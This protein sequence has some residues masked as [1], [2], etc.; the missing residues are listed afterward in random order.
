MRLRRDSPAY[1]LQSL[2]LGREQLDAYR[3]LAGLLEPADLDLVSVLHRPASMPPYPQPGTSRASGSARQ[4]SPCSY[5]DQFQVLDA[6]QAG[7]P[8]SACDMPISIASLRTFLELWA[9]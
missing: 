8:P 3:Q 5:P 2:A 6:Q 7:G 9:S 4:L 1:G